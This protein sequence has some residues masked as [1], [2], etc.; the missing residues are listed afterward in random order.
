MPLV[1]G[2]FLEMVDGNS[3]IVGSTTGRAAVVHLC[4]GLQADQLLLYMLCY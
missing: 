3:G 4:H 2:Q 1:I